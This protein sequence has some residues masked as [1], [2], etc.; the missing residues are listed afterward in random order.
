KRG[1]NLANLGWALLRQGRYQEALAALQESIEQYP[2][3]ADNFNGMG[4]T[5]LSMGNAPRQALEYLE[6]GIENK[7]YRMNVDK[8]IWGELLANRA[9]AY[10]Q[11]G[12][13][14]QA[15]Q[16]YA[17]ALAEAEKDCIPALAGLHVRGGYVMRLCGDRAQ[18]IEEL[19]FA[20]K[21]DP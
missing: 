4:E 17:Q 20:A 21:L 1:M 11:M 19:N 12:S 8:Y 10:A 6:R 14:E 9:W 5:L 2:E 13:F 3:G 7:R 15:R 18:A 16:S